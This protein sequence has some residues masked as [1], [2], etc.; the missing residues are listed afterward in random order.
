MIARCV[1]AGL[2]STAGLAALWDSGTIH[3]RGNEQPSAPPAP[4]PSYAESQQHQ[5]QQQQAHQAA[6]RELSEAIKAATELSS[7][8]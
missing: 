6:L 8:M 5:Q 2:A 7:R 4:P 1:A 3:S